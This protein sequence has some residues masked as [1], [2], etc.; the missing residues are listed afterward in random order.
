MDLNPVQS[1]VSFKLNHPC[2]L[3]LIKE[4]LWVHL[5]QQGYNTQSFFIQENPTTPELL[6][7]HVTDVAVHIEPYKQITKDNIYG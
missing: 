2:L 6:R 3:C 5:D 4:N 1:T 7:K